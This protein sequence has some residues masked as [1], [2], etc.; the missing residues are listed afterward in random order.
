MRRSLIGEVAHQLDQI[1][2]PKVPSILIDH[3]STPAIPQQPNNR[4]DPEP[5][6]A[7]GMKKEYIIDGKNKTIPATCRGD[8]NVGVST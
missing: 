1:R 7:R 2:K 6:F 4:E 5:V 8:R 3:A